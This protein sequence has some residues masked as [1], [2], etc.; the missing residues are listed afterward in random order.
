MG[1]RHISGYGYNALAEKNLRIFIRFKKLANITIVSESIN[2]H[3]IRA[4]IKW[5][6][7]TSKSLCVY[8]YVHISDLFNMDSILWRLCD[9][10]Y[11]L[12]HTFIC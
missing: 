12:S 1:L 2:I 8:I 5:K 11:C 9:F 4:V 10:W 3:R 7:Q 6:C